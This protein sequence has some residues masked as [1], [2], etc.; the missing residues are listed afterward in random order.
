MRIENLF[1]RIS[2]AIVCCILTVIAISGLFIQSS[3]DYS[4]FPFFEMVSYKNITAVI[5]IILFTAIYLYIGFKLNWNIYI[6]ISTHALLC[7]TYLLTVQLEPFSDMYSVYNIAVNGM[8]DEAGYLTIYNNQIPLTIYLWVITS[9]FG[10][11]ILVPKLFNMLFNCIILILIYKITK[12]FTGSVR[13]A[14]ICIWLSAI[15]IPSIL[16]INHIY[17]DVLFTMLTLAMVY[18]A[19]RGSYNISGMITLCLL[20]VLQYL[21]RPCGIIYIIAVAMYMIM[22]QRCRSKAFT[23]FAAAII[24]ISLATNINNRLFNVDTSRSFPVWS[25]IQMGINEAEFGFQNG[26]HSTDWTFRD[27]IDKYKNMGPS[28]VTKTLAKKE[29]WMWTEGT[30]QAERYGFGG[31]DSTFAHENRITDSIKDVDNSLIREL[32]DI[33]MKAQYY[34]YMLLALAGVPAAAKDTISSL[35]NY[36]ICGFACFYL[37]WEMKSRYIYSL[38]PLFIIYAVI[39]LVHIYN[40]IPHYCSHI[41]QNP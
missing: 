28:R 18:I 11:N 16:Y 19:V 40:R 39:G 17:N 20:S 6:A 35:F 41:S 29:L 24:L 12:E 15:W 38:Y 10:K 9:I 33:L 36:C 26:T 7:I 13:T 30:Y 32:T 34:V 23:I 31:Y 3:Y 37:V 4:D 2:T 22:H 21:I 8:N 25:F 27:C 1:H 5:G 14:G